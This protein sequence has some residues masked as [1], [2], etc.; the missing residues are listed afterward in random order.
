[1]PELPDIELYLHAL[2]PRVV[3]KTIERIRVVSPFV[4]R[5]FDPPTD[6]VEGK[7]VRALRRIGKRIVFELDGDDLFIVVHLMISGRF[8]W[9]DKIGA[10]PIGK[11]GLASFLFSNGTLHLVESSPKK[12]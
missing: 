4:L 3:G 7:A 2:Q 5:T 10:K 6:A 11:I 1:M 8:R 12:R 9:D